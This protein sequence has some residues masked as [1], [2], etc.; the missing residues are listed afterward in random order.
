MK[1]FLIC[2]LIVVAFGASAQEGNYFMD[3]KE[4]PFIKYQQNH[5]TFPSGDEN[6]F[7]SLYQKMDSIILF[8]DGKINIVHIG[9][10]HIQADIYSHQIRKKLQLLEHDMNGGRGLVF[11]FTM[12]KTNNPWNY[13]VRYT[14]SWSFCKNTQYK[15][16][17]PLGLTGI[18]VSTQSKSA[19]I[20]INPNVDTALPYSIET[21]KVF[22]PESSYSISAKVRDTL[23]SGVYDTLQGFTLIN[24]PQCSDFRL[25]FYLPDSISESLTI[26]GVLMENSDPGVVYHSIGVNGAKLESYLYCELYEQ[27]MSVIKPDLVIFSIGTNDG[28]TKYFN[29]EK[30]KR[31]YI[32]LIERTKKAAPNTKILITVPNDAYYYKRYVNENTLLLRKEILSI[33][34]QYNYG[35]WDF[36][37]IMGGL[38]SSMKWLNYDIMRYDRI[39]FNRKGYYLKGDL[40]LTA[41]LRGWEHN[42]TARSVHYFSDE[43]FSSQQLN[44]QKA[45]E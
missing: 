9:G 16:S 34:E 11:P 8:G 29:A 36:F 12:A 4:Y 21:L 43:Q 17:C 19:S 2:I 32:D 25:H 45:F 24:V 30:Y 5:L 31:E 27:Q 28:N 41:F 6:A 42:L 40:F 37:T 44:S 18:S 15:R 3:I 26:Y 39:H 13:K 38:N 1:Q 10:S 35:V 7:E 22:H 14:G 33:A 23:Y 20:Y